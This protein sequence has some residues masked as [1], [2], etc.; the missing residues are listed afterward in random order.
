[1]EIAKN[2]PTNLKIIRKMPN[3]GE[4]FK[5]VTHGSEHRSILKPLIIT[6]DRFSF[7]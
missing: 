2:V 6:K 4:W 5:Q 3:G 1:M 7:K